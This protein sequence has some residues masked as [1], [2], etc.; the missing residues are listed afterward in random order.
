MT[1]DATTWAWKIIDGCWIVFAAVWFA[2][3]FTT[4]RAVYGE[5]LG[6]RALWT[7]IVAIGALAVFKSP[8]GP[9]PLDVSVLPHSVFV[10]ALSVFLCLCGLAFAFWARATIG[11][12]WSGRVTLKENHELVERGPYRLVRHPI[13]S[14]LLLMIA[15]TALA[16]GR[17]GAFAGWLVIFAGLWIKLR[18]EERLML[19]TFPEQYTAYSRHVKRIIPFVL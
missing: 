1:N 17:I 5:N 18:N 12:N 13:Y 16:I 3:A 6:H 11:R 14:G 10:A 19:K 9:Y 8:R 2:A 7:A 15:A 4:K